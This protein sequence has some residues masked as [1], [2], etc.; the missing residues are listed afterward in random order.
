MLAIDFVVRDGAGNLQ[1]GSVAGDGVPASLIVGSG[2]DVSLNLRRTQVLEY[3]REGQ[4]LEVT[5]IDG[6]IIVIEGFFAAN[7]GAENQLYLSAD[8]LLAEVVLANDGTGNYYAQYVEADTFG[9]WSPDDDLYFIR[10]NDVMIADAA[11]ASGDVQAGMLAA[12]LL[13]GIGGLGSM[14]GIG[15]AAVAGAVVVDEVLDDDGDDGD[16]GPS[17]ITVT[18]T[19][20]TS[21]TGNTD[22]TGVDGTDYVVNE[23]DHSD[24]VEITGVSEPGATVTV[25]IGDVSKD[26]V[27]AD[28]GTWV[29]VFDPTEV[30]PGEYTTDVLVEVVN[31]DG[32]TASVT[33]TLI[34]DTI[35]NLG[36]ETATV[37]G[38]GVVNASEMSDGVQLTGTSEPGS[39]VVVTVGG[40]AYDA[41]VAEDGS[42]TLDLATGDLD[43][44]EYTLDVV[45]VSTDPYGNTSTVTQ[46]L[47]IDTV[48]EIE[49]Q[50]QGLV[51]RAEANEGVTLRGMSQPGSSVVVTYEG[52]EY[53]AIV[54]TDG[55]WS[56]AIPGRAIRSGEYTA[57]A[58][59]VATDANGNQATSSL[60]F[61]VDTITDV[62]LDTSGA[63]GDGTVNGAEQAGGVT[64]VGTAQAGATVA[65]TMNGYTVSVI[66]GG[67]GSWSADFAAYQVPTGELQAPVS[68][69]ATDAA[70]NTSTTNGTVDID[71]YVNTLT[72]S[73]API[74]G[75][76]VINGT[77]HG[78]AINLNGTVE[79]G[80]SVTVT[81]GGVTLV[82]S[83]DGAG[84]WSVTYPAGTLPTGEY[85]TQMVV[86]A[87]DAAGN[88]SSMSESVMVDTTAGIL[89]LSPNPI[90]TDDVVNFQEVQDGVIIHGTSNPGE[91][92]TVTLGGATHQ[93]VTGANGVWTTTYAN[94][95][96][97]GG[98]YDATITAMIT[99]AAGNTKMVSDTVHIDTVA[100]VAFD[101]APV[102]GN[103]I[104]N[105]AEQA[106]G[107]VLTGT[108][109]AGSTSVMITMEG[110]TKAA[111]VA[112]DGSWTVGFNASD[113]PVGEYTATM[114]AVATDKAGNTATTNDSVY[115]DNIVNK[116]TVDGPV[117]TDDVVNAAEASD[118]ILMTGKVEAGS[119]VLVSFGGI[120][121]T[122]S[123][124]A[125]G[126]WS[127]LFDASEIMSGE[128]TAEVTINA[129]DANGNT[130]SITDTFDVD[131]TAPGA[132]V[133]TSFTRVAG[134]GAV[135][136]IGT[137]GEEDGYDI[138]AVDA[139]GNVS[140]VEFTASSPYSGET[141]FS[142]DA[143]VPDGSQLVVSASDENG[144][145]NST[146]FVFDESGSNVVN[147]T[148][149]G[150]DGF[151]IGAIDL[152]LAESSELTLDAA[153]LEALS[154]NN[155]ELTIHGGSDDTVTI[156]GAT[157]SGTTN[158]GGN[159]Y[160]IYSLGDDSGSLLIQEDITVII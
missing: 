99:D 83:V 145:E 107:V 39:T 50:S 28:D 3:D 25:T 44:G 146:L 131:T 80:S 159:S 74:A 5:L 77:E 134:D 147:A 124:D 52:V 89:T 128:Y 27:V 103:D 56:A 155:N 86:N 138:H 69:V 14:L 130:D 118:G 141:E 112:A 152:Q 47:E 101:A 104:I 82:A 20:G 144:N 116:L 13:G 43:P 135:R 29:V 53:A 97:P 31:E 37:E 158:I 48:S 133:I 84:N 8:G 64:L 59:A 137:L 71:T 151:N 96:V 23:S 62:T 73:G 119:S 15:G 81:M 11:V 45:A 129:T 78:A 87:T 90:E 65:V 17:E 68:V 66:A 54:A 115:V 154:D 126:N 38:N 95:E 16:D 122:A 76:N 108:S 2:Q 21:E 30:L 12:P 49:F 4:A 123:V 79:V 19:G 149:A 63:G 75:D 136:R 18:V 156:A 150:L 70:G 91:I 24:G 7:G 61:E 34:V 55:S 98:T 125:A 40:V 35:A 22:A 36:F 67:N 6:R 110:V 57:Q 132:P 114:T 58:T 9:K 143:A 32:A 111:T 102:E 121:H 142:F 157:A 51:N 92:V 139:A 153:T 60:S 85:T 26:A 113:L 10:G 109:E 117:E 1:R 140:T 127:T 105:A 46:T 42:W 94:S 160:D 93:V 120:V 106:N 33:E 100:S 72:H 88:T 148:N 41:V